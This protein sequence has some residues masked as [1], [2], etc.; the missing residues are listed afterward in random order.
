MLFGSHLYGTNTPESDLDYK[1]IYI[2]SA[3]E[4]VLGT[5]QKTI[6]RGRN[7]QVCERNTKDDVD[8]EIFSLDR[9]LELLMDGQTVALDMLFGYMVTGQVNGVQGWE[10][11]DKIHENKDRLL[12][13]NVNAFVGY[14]RQQAAKYGI[15]GSRLDALKRTMELLEQLPERDKLFEHEIKL[16]ALVIATEQLVSLEKTPLI[17]VVMVPGPNKSDLMPHLHVCGRKVPYGSTVKFAK[18]VFGRILQ[19]YGQ[20]A[21]KA[22]LA[23][24]IDWKA[25]SHAVRV[26]EEALELLK[27]GKITFPRPEAELLTQIKLGKLP[28]EQVAEKIEQGLADLTEAHTTSTLRDEPDR[29][30]ADQL[31]YEIYAKTVKDS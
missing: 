10:L 8:T 20:R 11:M 24:G 13:R 2:P 12:T 17:E 21:Q 25:L 23:G 7:K 1:E 16:A 19:G 14:A 30:W 28:Y 3:R 29:E 22:H 4:I 5:Y 9:F 31:V 15:K 18:Q 6:L 26:N 27:T